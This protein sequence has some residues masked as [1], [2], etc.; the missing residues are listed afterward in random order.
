[1][2]DAEFA[3][4]EYR[5]A[6]QVLNR[7]TD[8]RVIKCAFGRTGSSAE[9]VPYG[10]SV[11]N[12]PPI[13]TNFYFYEVAGNNLPPMLFRI[14]VVADTKHFDEILSFFTGRYG[15]VSQRHES[16]FTNKLGTQFQNTALR[17][18]NDVSVIQLRRHGDWFHRTKV[19]FWIKPGPNRIVPETLLPADGEHVD[20]SDVVTTPTSIYS[21]GPGEPFE[22]PQAVYR[23]G[24]QFFRPV[25]YE[26]VL[27]GP[28]IKIKDYTLI[29]VY[30][31]D[32]GSGNHSR[33]A[34]L[35]I[36]GKGT[37]VAHEHLLAGCIACDVRALNSD[38]ASNFVHLRIGRHEGYE[39][40]AWFRDGSLSVDRTKLD[41]S[42]PLDAD[43][44]KS[45]YEELKTCEGPGLR[46][47]PK[48]C[49][50]YSGHHT[51]DSFLDGVK[52][53]YPGFLIAD[54]DTACAEA[55][56]AGR[57]L[58]SKHFARNFCQREN[59]P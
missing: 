34:S 57:K 13:E 2:N 20:F 48:T 25:G 28:P 40:S 8:L 19:S 36:E 58:D 16:P 26:Y 47:D 7:N 4:A 21:T 41:P 14:D 17:F 11:G 43:T 15:P 33:S 22:Y 38:H 35:I 5:L 42:E 10:L 1:M 44:C 46:A 18:E 52:E 9:F 45:L 56:C 31:Q 12:G 29:P 55:M 30:G 54:F 37:A 51:R 39:T 50:G 3:G 6:T 24:K 27:L 59:L 53:N 32:G 23:N 49:P